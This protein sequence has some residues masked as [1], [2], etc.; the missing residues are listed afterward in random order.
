MSGLQEIC[1]SMSFEVIDK[2]RKTIKEQEEKIESLERE[3]K[4]LKAVRG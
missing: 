1:L 2:F 4:E 3:I